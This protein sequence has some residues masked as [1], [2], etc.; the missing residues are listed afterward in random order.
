[1]LMDDNQTCI[2]HFTIYTNIESLHCTPK[3]NVYANQ[4]ST[5][6]YCLYFQRLTVLQINAFAHRWFRETM[7]LLERWHSELS[8]D[9]IVL[10]FCGV[11]KLS[12]F[13]SCLESVLLKNCIFHLTVSKKIF[14]AIFFNIPIFYLLEMYPQTGEFS[15]I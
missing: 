1:M 7:F 11:K 2:N 15:K 4:I 5:K 10:G 12:V 6:N 13:V 9:L 3:I 8:T 14:I